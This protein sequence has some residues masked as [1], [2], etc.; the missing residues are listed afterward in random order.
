M[1]NHIKKISL[2]YTYIDVGWWYQISIPKLPSGK[3]DYAVAFPNEIA[4]N[5]EQASALTDINDIGR[6]VARIIV[7]DRTLNKLVF[8]Y[9]VLKTQQEV[10]SYLEAQSRETIPRS[11]VGIILLNCVHRLINHSKVTAEK[12]EQR[13]IDAKNVIQSGPQTYQNST[14]LWIAEYMYSWGV[15]GDNTPEYA[16]YLGYLSVKDLY[17]DFKFTPFES[18]IADVLGGKV[19]AVYS[20]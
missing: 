3:I 10:Y 15:R 19:K 7:D 6:Y 1:I 4:G 2:P 14:A 5:G 8:A 17:P 9:N 20:S 12:L 11:Y 18:Y 13:I 16:E